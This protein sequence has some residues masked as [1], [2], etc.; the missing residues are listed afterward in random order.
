MTETTQLL[1]QQ[2]I[3]NIKKL[4]NAEVTSSIVCHSTGN[5]KCEYKLTFIYDDYE[6][7]PDPVRPS[8]ELPS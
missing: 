2:Q 7:T 1:L 3:E 6:V 5:G 8:V 4:L